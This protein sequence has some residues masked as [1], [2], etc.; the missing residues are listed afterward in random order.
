MRIAAAG[1]MALAALVVGTVASPASATPPTRA[2]AVPGVFVLE[3]VCD[4]PI[5]YDETVNKGVM[6][7][8]PD[9]HRAGTGSYKVRITN[10]NDPT[11]SMDI[12]ATGP[13]W[14]YPD[15][16]DKLGGHTLFILFQ[17][18]DFTSGLY[19][20]TGNWSIAFDDQGGIVSITGN[21]H[22]GPNLCSKIA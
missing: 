15:G 12:N 21:G 19:L 6:T 5:V 1:A 22:I 3:G 9:G 18:W 14:F 16:T 8:F 11:K 10:A 17:G 7:F 13:Q 20:G 2:H 4:F